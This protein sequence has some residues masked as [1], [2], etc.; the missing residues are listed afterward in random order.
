MKENLESQIN[1]NEQFSVIRY[2]TPE[3]TMGAMDGVP[4]FASVESDGSFKDFPMEDALDGIREVGIWG[5]VDAKRMIHVWFDSSVDFTGLL[6]FLGHEI[7]HM[8]MVLDAERKDMSDD[9]LTIEIEESADR[10]G[11]TAKE[12]FRL[13]EILVKE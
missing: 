5:H 1:R 3:E 7:G 2:E 13:A 8:M 11:F 6:F 4:Q 9:D 10:Y 12:A